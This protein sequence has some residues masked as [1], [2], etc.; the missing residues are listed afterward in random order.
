[1]PY[2]TTTDYIFTEGLDPSAV[3]TS[4]EATALLSFL[5]LALPNDYRGMVIVSTTT[6]A[7]SGQPTGYP[8]DWYAWQQRCI[9]FDPSTGNLFG[10]VTGLGWQPITP[11]AGSIGTDELANAAVTAAKIAPSTAL[12]LLRTNAAGTA[13][14]WVALSSVLSNGSVPLSA[15]SPTG[16]SSTLGFLRS[17][18]TTN[19]WGALTAFDINLAIPTGGLGVNKLNQGAARYILR[20]R[21]DAAYAEWITPTG[22]FDAGEIP[23]T[24]LS[25]GSGNANKAAVVNATGTAF[26]YRALPVAPT[27]TVRT[28]VAAAL[29][30]VG[31]SIVYPHTLA[32]IPTTFAAYFV[33]ITTNNNY[34]VGDYILHSEVT[35]GGSNDE[36]PAFGLTADTTNLTLVQAN[37]TPTQR[38]FLN[39]T[40]GTTA[41]FNPA[42]WNVIFKA[43]LLA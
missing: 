11:A 40:L 43:T 24:L 25:P 42:E 19:F 31:A 29:P 28:S 34:A 16:A 39:K 33:C 36:R 7:T 22:I 30:G 21:T 8:T 17:N 4:P 1:M 35:T 15:I 10:Y 27:V 20:M 37:I 13:T 23:I 12:Y 14:E 2:P 41:T 9:W 3:F 26:E 18:G 38:N 6:P 32:T 5:R